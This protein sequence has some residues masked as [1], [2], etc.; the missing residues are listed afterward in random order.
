MKEQQD[1]DSKNVL[2]MG[3]S[4][5]IGIRGIRQNMERSA[6]MNQKEISSAFADLES[7]KQKS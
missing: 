7:L 5:A 6:M 1:L 4:T 2:N 3:G